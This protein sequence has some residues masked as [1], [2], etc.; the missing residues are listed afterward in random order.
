[1][2]VS[3]YWLQEFVDISGIN[4]D[5]LYEA[6]NTIG[7]E[8]DS[9]ENI[10]IP[11]G[12][13]IGY[14]KQCEKHTQADKLSVCQ[15]DI[16]DKTL[17]IVC[18][19]KN[20]AKDMFVP[21]ATVGTI[22]GDD[23][24]IKQTTLRGESSV[25]MICSSSE[26][27][28]P[29]TNDGIMALDDSIG[30]L[31]VGKELNEYKLLN[32]TIIDIELTAN[33]GDCMSV[34]GV[35]RD[36]GVYFDIK[37]NDLDLNITHSDK[38]V[39]QAF[40]FAAH[41]DM[42]SNVLLSGADI[43]TFETKILY[44]IR[45]AI[46]GC[47]SDNSLKNIASYA[48]HSVGV[49]F[50]II[51]H[52]L[53]QN[54]L[55]LSVIDIKPDSRGFDSIY[56]SEKI[57]TIGIDSNETN[58]PKETTTSNLAI[59]ALYINPDTI[60]K[61]VFDKK[62]KTDDI[63]YKSSRGSEPNLNL[64]IKYFQYILNLCGASIYSGY[65][66]LTNNKQITSLTIDIN[67]INNI[68]GQNI[69]QQTI[70][71]ILENLQFSLKP[72]D[73]TI[74]EIVV[75]YFRTDIKNIADITEEIVRM[76]GIDNITAVPLSIAERNKQNYT[77]TKQNFLNNIKQ[78]AVASGFYEQVSFLF[79][80][81]QQ[82]AKYGFDVIEEKKDLSNPINS[83]LDTMRTT[84]LLN[85]L[86]SAKL[87]QNQGLAQVMLFELGEVYDKSRNQRNEL[88]F[89]F[90]GYK[91]SANIQNQSKP[92]K[93]DFPIFVRK[94][95]DIIGEFELVASTSTKNSLTNPYVCADIV[96]NSQTIGYIAQL[97]IDVADDFDIDQ[98][99]ICT[100][101]IDMLKQKN[102]KVKPYSKYQAV[103]RD[104]SIVAPKDMPY[105]EIANCIKSLKIEQIQ[106]FDLVDIYTD[107]KL[108]KHESLTIRFLLQSHDDTMS[109]ENI[110][111]IMDDIVLHLDQKLGLKL[112]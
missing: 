27:G 69:E 33:R 83:E 21:V 76:I 10:T 1:M 104:I 12:V 87:N 73:T 26:I 89:L 61:M 84:L 7:L 110:T 91:E 36:L 8:V 52:R 102:I 24:T 37:Q 53:K 9:I 48:T 13:V 11:D 44:D 95:V 55:G 70:V 72:I 18:G 4:D 32:D 28:L 29:K 57:T 54:D 86:E 23:F 34:Y 39:G 98:T 5:K 6:L 97:H 112:R 66:K 111:K 82:T 94:I 71:K 47:H 60:N 93:V 35:A 25:G 40:S 3:R 56:S 74:F 75:P 92:D 81:R 16:G 22:L 105:I 2:I 38:A 67:D 43:S 103:H 85:L 65:K 106:K 62:I 77:T 19:A 78:K 88:S 50:D 17:Q 46:A 99:Y 108:K 101:D 14:V 64:G 79:A 58:I 63:Y 49:L 42:V 107:K 41:K 20:V 45:T 15:V 80:N 68:I 96:Q 51:A 59:V 109:E 100:I 31:I 90:C 30:E